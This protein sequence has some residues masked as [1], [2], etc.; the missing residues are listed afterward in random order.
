[1]RPVKRGPVHVEKRGHVF[2][3]LAFVDLLACVLD[4]LRRQFGLAPEFQAPAFRG[5]HSGAGPFAYQA[6]LKLGQYAY[7]LPHGAA[8]RRFGVDRFC[9]RSEFDAPVF[10]VVEHGYQ[11]AQAAAQ[12]VEFLQTAEKGRAIG[13]RSR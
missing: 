11:V 13:G 5:L 4:L 8:C 10:Q 12:P 1:M 3:A 7:Y 2:A 9:Q 6:A